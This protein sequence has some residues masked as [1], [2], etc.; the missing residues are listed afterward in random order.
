MSRTIRR[1]GHTG[2]K[3]KDKDTSKFCHHDITPILKGIKQSQK[4]KEKNYFD[5]FEEPLF[6]QPPKSRGRSW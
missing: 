1:D 5:K 2:K 3:V 4:A 6:D